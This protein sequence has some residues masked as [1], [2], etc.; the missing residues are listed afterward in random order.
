MR[1]KTYEEYLRE[2]AHDETLPKLSE[3]EYWERIEA[4][5]PD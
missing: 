2:S 1:I 3:K 5:K 4:S